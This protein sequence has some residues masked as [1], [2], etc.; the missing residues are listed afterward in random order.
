MCIL[1]ATNGV[2]FHMFGVDIDSKSE[3]RLLMTYLNASMFGQTVIA[4]TQHGHHHRNYLDCSQ[5][6]AMESRKSLGDDKNRIAFEE[7]ELH[8]GIK[9]WHDTLFE[10]KLGEE[11][12]WHFEES[13]DNVLALPFWSSA[14]ARKLA[15]KNV[16]KNRRRRKKSR[17]ET[18]PQTKKYDTHDEHGFWKYV[19][20]RLKDDDFKKE[21]EEKRRNAR[22]KGHHRAT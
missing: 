17:K 21:I 16:R 9:D 3:L 8:R 13:V 2:A 11:R 19:I 12:E 7:L 14:R 18:L 15:D 4:G 22:R 1:K 6:K 5:E 10:G 20:Q